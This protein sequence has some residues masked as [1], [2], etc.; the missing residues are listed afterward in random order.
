M[1]S[2]L[3]VR[4]ANVNGVYALGSWVAA[5]VFKSSDLGQLSVGGVCELFI[6]LGSGRLASLPVL[7]EALT[8]TRLRGT[9][10]GPC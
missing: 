7:G 2:S 1:A 4:Y 5:S 8:Q 3:V 9:K 10:F 6:F